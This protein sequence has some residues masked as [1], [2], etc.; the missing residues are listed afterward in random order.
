MNDVVLGY[1][2]GQKFGRAAPRRAS[3][4]HQIA[5]RIAHMQVSS[6]PEP[7]GTIDLNGLKKRW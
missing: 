1:D 3:N 7:H 6:H 4:E 2:S 5:V